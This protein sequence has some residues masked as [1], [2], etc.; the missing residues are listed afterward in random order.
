MQSLKTKTKKGRGSVANF[1]SLYRQ[2][3][4]FVWENDEGLCILE[5]Y[6]PLPCFIKT[7]EQSP[8]CNVPNSEGIQVVCSPMSYTLLD[9]DL[10][11]KSPQWAGTAN[12]KVYSLKFLSVRK[13]IAL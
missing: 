6:S 13:T 11:N 12:S 5:R 7:T 9:I 2:E 8:N 4:T 1:F 10:S 3:Y